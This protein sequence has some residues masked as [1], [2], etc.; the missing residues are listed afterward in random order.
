MVSSTSGGTEGNRPLTIERQGSFRV[1]GRLIEVA[2][3]FDPTDP[4][5]TF[6]DTGGQCYHVDHMYAE[7][8]VPPS[9]RPLPLV[10]VHGNNMDGSC[11]DTT[12]DGREGFRTIFLR[13]G[14]AVY[15]VDFPRRGRS[16]IP[17]FSGPLG[18]LDGDAVIPDRTYRCGDRWSFH[19]WRMGNLPKP[20]PGSQFPDDPAAVEQALLLIQPS[21]TDDPQVISDAIVALLDRIGPAVLVTHSQ[22]GLVGWLA[23][24]KSAR[25]KGIIAY[26]PTQFVFPE[27]AMPQA[28][29][30]LL[31]YPFA[32]IPAARSDWARLLGIPIQIV[33]GDFIE[34]TPQA[35]LALE[36][37]RRIVHSPAGCDGFVSAVEQAGGDITCL[38][39]PAI[40]ERGNS[41]FVMLERNNLKVAGTALDFLLRKGLD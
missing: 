41:H 36:F 12:P 17:S 27:D 26:E 28:G 8:Q 37:W 16:G 14:F 1:G 21:F 34:T 25:V 20:F 24:V 35:D 5:A 19:I 33:F 13:H 29:A 39:L 4:N 30:P 23:A 18:V 9:A 22:G 15:V 6:N 7:Y 11:W 40:G 10:F 2:G 3:R 32:G 31:G 38:H